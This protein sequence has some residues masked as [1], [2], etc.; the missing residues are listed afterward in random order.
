MIV[1]EAFV[2]AHSSPKY[3][4]G[5]RKSSYVRHQVC[6]MVSN[7]ALAVVRYVINCYY[8]IFKK[9]KNPPH[10]Q[11]KGLKCV[12]NCGYEVDVTVHI[13]EKSWLS[14]NSGGNDFWQKSFVCVVCLSL[15]H[16]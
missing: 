7:V 14:Y 16:I 1:C 6:Q 13:S 12:Q 9:V 5:V 15:I 3:C 8:F 10:P 4:V 2:E 11:A